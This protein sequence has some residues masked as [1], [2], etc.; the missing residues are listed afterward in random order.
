MT[1]QVEVVSAEESVWAGQAKEVIARSVEGDI[2]IMGG[3]TPVLAILGEGDVELLGDNGTRVG[4]FRVDGGFLSVE[5]DQVLVVV[6][7]V[8]GAGQPE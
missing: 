1:V 7:H 3:H 5:N 2:G 8:I 6:E 4:K